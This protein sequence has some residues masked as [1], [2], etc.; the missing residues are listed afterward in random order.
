MSITE[1]ETKNRFRISNVVT[2]AWEVLSANFVFYFAV[3]VLVAVPAVIF[4][5]FYDPM[6]VIRLA[7]SPAAMQSKFGADYIA[8]YNRALFVTYPVVMVLGLVCYGVCSLAAFQHLRGEGRPLGDNLAQALRRFFPLLGVSFLFGLGIGL[9]S[10]LLTFP[11]IML[12][13]R[14]AI[15]RQICVIEKAGP[16]ESLQRSTQ[17]TDGYRWPLFGL[18]ILVVVVAV[19]VPALFSFLVASVGGRTVALFLSALIQGAISAYLYCLSVT[20][21]QELVNIK[22]GTATPAVVAVFD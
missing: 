21:Y 18:G 14:W 10:I 8:G 16:I 11:G 3:A 5:L 9:A 6:E 22:E 13:V 15:F 2:R 1:V 4:Q 7:G 12:A 19:G 20:I 17:L